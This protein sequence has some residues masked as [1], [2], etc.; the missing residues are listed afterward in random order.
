[1]TEKQ[2][3]YE[4]IVALLHESRRNKIL[5]IDNRY[6]LING[7]IGLYIKIGNIQKSDFDKLQHERLIEVHQ[8]GFRATA[9]RIAYSPY[10]KYMNQK[11]AMKYK[12]KTEETTVTKEAPPY[13]YDNLVRLM[14]NRIY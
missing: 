2:I 9:Y 14:E 1:M 5:C 4:K 10:L 8:K 7:K 12:M 3:A 13:S 11:K 6:T